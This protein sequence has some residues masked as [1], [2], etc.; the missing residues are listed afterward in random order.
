MDRHQTYA[1]SMSDDLPIGRH[2]VIPSGELSWRFDPSGGPGGQH[3]NKAATRAEVAWDLGGSPSVPDGLRE[4]M[5]ER[6]GNRA[7]GGVVTV[8]VD[9][10]RSQWR[11]R[12]LARRRL[13]EVLTDAARRPKR[14]IGTKASRSSQRRRL[15]R[16]RRRGEV[17]R[18]RGPIHPD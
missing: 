1:Q 13:A 6:L 5:L 7:P 8:S 18:L 9:D 15:E 12:V 3:A 16:K 14:R 11:N 10:T 2:F 17:K 4:R